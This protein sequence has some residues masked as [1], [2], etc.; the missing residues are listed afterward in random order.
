MIEENVKTGPSAEA[1]MERVRFLEETNQWML[2][3]LEVVS[4]IDDQ[5][6]FPQSHW[7]K[8]SIYGTARAHLRRL[9][10]FEAVAF[11]RP[12]EINNEFLLDEVEPASE[13]EP[14]I[15]E[16]NQLIDEGLFGWAL[17]QNRPIPIP[18][19][20]DARVFVLH[21]LETR[22][23]VIG[24][25]VG[26]ANGSESISNK[27]ALNLM[28]IV[29]FKT[30]VGLEQLELYSRISN[31]NRILE[32][33]VEERTKEL[34]DAKDIA[35]RA[36]RL[37]SE[38]VANMSHE[39]RTPLSG[40]I[41][42]SELL[43]ESGYGKET[44]RYATMIR[45]QGDTLL[46]IINDIL[47]FSKIE[48]GKLTIERISFDL[49]QVI[50]EV[51]AILEGK[52]DAK[53]LRVK[54]EYSLG[55]LSH[56]DGDP[57]RVR[58][59]IMNLVGNAIKFTN[60]GFITVRAAIETQIPEQPVE[61]ITVMDTGIGIAD[62]V[63]TNLF[64]SFTQGDGS[65]TRKYGGTGL[66]LAISKQLVELM[67][68][69]IGVHSSLG[70][71]STFWFTLPLRNQ[72]QSQGAVWPQPNRIEPSP[73]QS[74]APELPTPDAGPGEQESFNKGI[75][76]LIAEDNQVN[77]EVSGEI[78]T[79]LGFQV[80]VV[81]NGLCAFEEN[82]RSP[83]DIIFMDCQMP[84]MDGYESTRRI[85]ENERHNKKTIIIAMTA[86]A[87]E[88][89]RE[90][91]LQAGMDDYIAK[92]FKRSDFREILVKW[93][94]HLHETRN[95]P[96]EQYRV[97]GANLPRADNVIDRMRIQ[98]IASINTKSRPSLLARVIRQFNEDVPLRIAAMR[99]AAQQKD[100]VHVQ[101]VAHSL[102]GSSAQIGAVWLANVCEKIEHLAD[103]ESFGEMA[104]LIETLEDSFTQAAAEL[105]TY[106]PKEDL[107]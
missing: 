11:F 84:V 88:G 19:R 38:F 33:K 93:I 65:T 58:Q 40:I 31:Q 57:L 32:Q 2:E 76:I 72:P 80:S 25:F 4:A 14:I 89:D 87:L 52:A 39:L 17:H 78:L 56:Y 97:S 8:S 43:I 7:D 16:V 51:V 48:A 45:N 10:G 1:L 94:A 27:L 30:A 47:D 26:I 86:N 41:G 15:S 44:R 106:I 34:M 71:G 46:A 81:P 64:Q 105:A 85:R 36:S 54:C 60:H 102:R 35:L 59:V 49:V 99:D 62:E 77:Q 20:S 61:K 9:V 90:R 42:I 91:C 29:L 95:N 5:R 23:N 103:K 83:F 70:K 66:G 75:R 50:A 12:D 104:S 21:G 101:K 79:R 82:E 69:T 18:S 37:K 107:Q 73:N 3:S 67:G 24:M 68:G 13:R 22:R 28:S 53:G 96:T 100:A 63:Q 98:E 55:P 74:T 92:P 6:S